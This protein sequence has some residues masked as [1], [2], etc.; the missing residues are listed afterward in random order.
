MML[1]MFNL[2]ILPSKANGTFVLPPSTLYSLLLSKDDCFTARRL[3]L[4]DAKADMGD[5]ALKP[6]EN[7]YTKS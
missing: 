4:D 7:Q 1:L 2:D 3:P 6:P 5:A